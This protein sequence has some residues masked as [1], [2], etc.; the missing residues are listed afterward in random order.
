[1]LVLLKHRTSEGTVT[2]VYA[3][4]DEQRNSAVVLKEHLERLP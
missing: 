2:F 1:L 4:H 3:A